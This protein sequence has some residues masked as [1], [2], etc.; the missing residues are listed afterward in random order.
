M[1]KKAPVLRERREAKSTA[2]FTSAISA[3]SVLRNFLVVNGL[4]NPAEKSQ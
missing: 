3:G 4:D 1:A 2:L